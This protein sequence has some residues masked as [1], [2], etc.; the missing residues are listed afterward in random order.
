MQ[1]AL[2]RL[3]AGGNHTVLLV[4]HRLSTVQNADVIAVV[5]GGA[6]A[7]HGTHDELVARDG[8][9][10]GWVVVEVEGGEEAEGAGWARAGQDVSSGVF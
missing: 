2:D 5:D 7:E 10:L 4:A 3:I 9:H 1:A 6:I 8:I